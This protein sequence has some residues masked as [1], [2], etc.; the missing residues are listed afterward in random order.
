MNWNEDASS[1]AGVSKPSIGLSGSVPVLSWDS[2]RVGAGRS[3]SC[4]LLRPVL[5][6]LHE[7]TGLEYTHGTNETDGEVEMAQI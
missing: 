2:I 4:I 6:D 7:E 5:A 1:H 3:F